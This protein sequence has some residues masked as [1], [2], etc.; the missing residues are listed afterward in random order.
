MFTAVLA[1]GMMQGA[2][3]ITIGVGSDGRLYSDRFHRWYNVSSKTLQG[4]LR[5]GCYND[6]NPSPITSV[7]IVVG[8]GAP[9]SKIDQVFSILEKQGWSRDK[10]SVGNWEQY[11]FRPN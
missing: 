8:P 10:V 2:C 3:P 1:L 4:D 9:Q 6:S 5:G 11:P 7:K